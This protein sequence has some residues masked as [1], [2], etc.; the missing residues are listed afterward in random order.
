MLLKIRQFITLSSLTTSEAMRQPICLILAISSIFLMAL[1]PI[2]SLHQLG[3]SGKLVRDSSLA[4]HFL[5]GLL[6]SGYAAGMALTIE[7]KSGTAS[8]VLSKPVSRELFFLSKFAGIAMLM[9]LYSSCAFISEL[10][11]TKALSQAYYMNTPIAGLLL[12]SP[13]VAILIAGFVNYRWKRP[14]TSQA[15]LA[16]F[17]ILGLSLC[18]A[19]TIQ[20]DAQAD[21]PIEWR[22]LPA[23]VLI[24]MAL[25]VMTGVTVGFASRLPLIPTQIATLLIFLFGL[26]SDY[27]FGRHQDTSVIASFFYT[28]IPNWQHFWMTD[29]LTGGGHIPWSYVGT[30]SLYACVYLCAVL[31]LGVLSFKYSEVK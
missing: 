10:L 1:I 15:F 5:F 9:I 2:L 24:T 25:C 8:A 7:M 12:G 14:F 17:V 18:I 21:H 30:T 3:E 16:L 27:L 6:I 31:C 4:I 22:L 23:S 29:A 20:P 13:F 28:L 11:A 19:L 26:M